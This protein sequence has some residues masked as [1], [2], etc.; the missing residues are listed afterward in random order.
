MEYELDWLEEVFLELDDVPYEPD[1]TFKKFK[2][3]EVTDDE[4]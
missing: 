3:K 1:T 4:V 2:W